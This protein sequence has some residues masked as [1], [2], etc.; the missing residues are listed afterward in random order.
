MRVERNK[1]LTNLVESKHIGMI[2]IITGLRRCGKSFLLFN[3]FCDHLK[4]SGVEDDHIIKVDLEDRR[5]IQLRQPDILLNYI[6][7]RMTDND[8]YYILI[9]EI[10]Y[11]AE[12]EDVLNS[13]LKV[14]N[15]DVYVTGS[16][17][18]FLSKDVITEFRGRGFEI[19]I[20]PL[21]FSEFFSA[22][23]GSR[24]E[25]LEEYL[26]FGGLPELIEFKNAKQKTDYLKGLFEKTYLT[27]IKARYKIEDDIE[28]SEL[29][30][31]VA[32]SVGG[33]INP[34]RIKNTFKSVAKS[35]LSRQ[36]INR[37]LEILEEAFLIERS[38][39]Y[40]IKG[41]RYIG[42]PAKY[43][44]SD[45]GLR[46]ARINFRQHEFPHL[47]ENLIYNELRSRGMSVDVGV[48]SL[49]T[50]NENGVSRRDQLEVDFVCNQGSKRCYVQ[51]AFRLPTKEKREQELRSLNN[52]GD[53]FSK[54]IITEN[55]I[56]KYQ[57][58]N[59]VVFINIYDFLLDE[60]SLTI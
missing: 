47:M 48:V 11:V 50:K 4:E 54:F 44:F 3:L 60:N 41:R 25:A 18:K 31:V 37:Y 51:S 45:V 27:D 20:S 49:N 58:D 16:N 26:T 39:R 13:Y 14:K 32:S 29:V 42:T 19:K 8:M 7:S 33:L 30:N 59:G 10:Q 21:S 15:A 35:S 17:S 43:Y 46:N 38:E 56:M 57:D 6:D 23:N 2:K 40:D 12:F 36:T 53:S 1:Y 24:E 9:D 5:N 22:F 52:I 28:L 55:P 34:T